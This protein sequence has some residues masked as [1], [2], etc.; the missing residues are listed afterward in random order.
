[1][2]M[3]KDIASNNLYY[4]NCKILLHLMGTRYDSLGY[5]NCNNVNKKSRRHNNFAWFFITFY[6][7]IVFFIVIIIT[8]ISYYLYFGDM[9][10]ASFFPWTK[11]VLNHWFL[12]HVW[13]DFHFSFLVRFQIHCVV[14][15]M[16]INTLNRYN[17]NGFE[18]KICKGC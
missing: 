14:D 10:C 15:W 13:L 1:M 9:K 12:F 8:N 3:V 2:C 17:I 11:N 18:I 5:Y 7:I 6:N 16:N 4:Y